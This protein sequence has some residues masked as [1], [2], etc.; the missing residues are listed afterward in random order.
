MGQGASERLELSWADLL[1]DGEAQ[2]IAELQM[3]YYGGGIDH[4]GAGP[5]AQIETFNVVEDLDGQKVRIGGYVL[6]LDFTGSRELN[7]FLLVPYIG[8][9]IHVPPPPP[10]QLV[11]VTT[12]APVEVRGLWDPVFLDGVMRTQRHDNDLGNTAYTLELTALT[13]YRR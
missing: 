1:P 9:C 3:Q 5:M 12:D 10:N 8:A 13:P 7:R 11:F 4:F 2:R 6:P